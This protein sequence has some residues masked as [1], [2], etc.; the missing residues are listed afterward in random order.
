M[1]AS[2]LNAFS[3]SAQFC[4]L[5]QSRSVNA[6]HC[7]HA[8]DGLQCIWRHTAKWAQIRFPPAYS[9]GELRWHNCWRIYWRKALWFMHST[10]PS[11]TYLR[12]T[13]ASVICR[14]TYFQFPIQ[15][16]FV[17]YMIYRSL[18]RISTAVYYWF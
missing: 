1:C 7:R 6:C 9:T 13:D 15:S 2:I 4:P 17:Q 5:P 18:G 10:I 16:A 12:V 8:L 14:V 3:V 11:V